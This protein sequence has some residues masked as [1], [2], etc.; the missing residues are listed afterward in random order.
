[1]YAVFQT[2]T[3]ANPNN[4]ATQY[5]GVEG[6]SWSSTEAQVSQPIPHDL[7]VDRLRIVLATAPGAG[8]T[9][10]FTLMKNGVAT[11]ITCAITGASTFANQDLSNSVSFTQG[12]TISLRCAP[13]GSPTVPAGFK[14]TLRQSASGCFAILSGNGAT[15]LSAGTFFGAQN[16]S[17]GGNSG[18]ESQQYAPV[19]MDCAEVKNLFVKLDVAPGTGTSYQV[20]VRKNSADTSPLLQVTVADSATT[21]NDQTHKPAFAPGDQIAVRVVISGTPAAV[22]MQISMTV[23]PTTDGDAFSLAGCT[24]GARTDTTPEYERH[25]TTGAGSFSTTESAQQGIY[26]ACTIKSFYVRSNAGPGAASSGKKFDIS[27]RLNGAT[28]GTTVTLLETAVNANATGLAVAVNDDDLI[29]T[30]HVATNTPTGVRLFTG[31][32][33]TMIPSSQSKSDSETGAGTDVNV[34]GVQ[35]TTAD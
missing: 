10:T 4:T 3:G 9:W 25:I 24:A 19:P 8:K 7:T 33:Y 6:T 5:I 20:T 29:C 34:L 17:A 22:R 14:M 11:G 15:Q 35:I 30:M 31:I 23:T 18:T 16:A 27:L 13:S 28:V 12:D 21:G 2:F 26:A 1:M 32:C